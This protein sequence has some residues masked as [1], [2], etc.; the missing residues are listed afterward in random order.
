MNALKKG[1]TGNDVTIFESI[2]KKMGY[3]DGEIDTNFGNKCVAACN[4]FQKDYP[5]CGTDG[6]PDGSFGSKC[7]RKAFA[8]MGA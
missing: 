4:A 8:L 6:K 7:W 2:M 5:E 3:Y 1:S